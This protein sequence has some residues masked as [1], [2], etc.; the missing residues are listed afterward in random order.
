MA[1]ADGMADSAIVSATYT[2]QGATPTFNPPGGSYLLPQQVSIASA[3]PGMTIYY[4]Q[5]D[6][7]S[8]GNQKITSFPKVSTIPCA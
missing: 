2:L 7:S 1:V 3:S 6:F 5:K 8:N 4:T